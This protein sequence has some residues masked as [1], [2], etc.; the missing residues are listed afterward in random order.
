MEQRQVTLLLEAV[1]RGESGAPDRLLELVYAELRGLAAGRMAREGAGHTLQATALVHEAWMRLAGDS[2]PRF[3]DRAHFFGA[4]SQAMRRILVERARRVRR[5]K[6]GGAQRREP[7]EQAEAELARETPSGVDLIALDEALAALEEH[8]P[9][10]AQ[11]VSLRYFAGLS[12]EQ[13]AEALGLSPRTVKREWSLARAWL[14]R[15][16]GGG[17]AAPNEA[18]Q[19]DPF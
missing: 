10:M 7:L 5:E 12:V 19:A 16:M 17:A 9:R 13:A 18:D 11:I 15:R 1:A 3:E 6:H 2:G 14:F 8:D 4:A